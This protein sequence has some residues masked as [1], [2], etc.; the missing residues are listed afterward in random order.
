M[1]AEQK[2]QPTIEVAGQDR[3]ERSLIIQEV[4]VGMNLPDGGFFRSG[5]L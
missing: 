2:R 1:Y 5:E 4:H 3:G